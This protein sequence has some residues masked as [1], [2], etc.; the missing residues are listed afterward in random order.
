MAW[1]MKPVA[2][3]KKTRIPQKCRIRRPRQSEIQQLD[4]V[5]GQEH[6]GGF[7]IS[8]N[9]TEIVQGLQ[10]PQDLAFDIQRFRGGNH[11]R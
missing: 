5:P 2:P 1:P 4:A 11:T 6:I 8:V 9:D 7:Q 10:R 3:V